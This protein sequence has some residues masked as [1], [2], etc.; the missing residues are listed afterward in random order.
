MY[1]SKALCIIVF[2]S[3]G[4]DESETLRGLN[5]E[6]KKEIYFCNNA[7]KFSS[8]LLILIHEVERSNSFSKYLVISPIKYENIFK[9][10]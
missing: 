9:F 10:A 4:S 2:R 5:K 6:Q 1:V 8:F 3:Q 7:K